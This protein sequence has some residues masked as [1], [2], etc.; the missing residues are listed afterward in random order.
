MDLYVVKV[1]LPPDTCVGFSGHYLHDGA[2]IWLVDE[3]TVEFDFQPIVG[4]PS[5]D[6]LLERS[7]GIQEPI[8][9]QMRLE[10]GDW[11]SADRAVNYSYRNTGDIDAVIIMT[12]LEN[13]WIVTENNVEAVTM[14]AAGCKGVCRRR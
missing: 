8:T 12:V 10:V 13:R 6:L 7:S 11:V 9:A 4:W 5:P 1:T 2:A 3:G 14:F